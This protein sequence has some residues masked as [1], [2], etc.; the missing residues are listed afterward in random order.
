MRTLEFWVLGYGLH[1]LWQAPLILLAAWGM[2]RLARGAGVSIA[3]RIWVGALLLE[4]LL[5]ACPVGLGDLWRAARVWLGCGHGRRGGPGGG[6]SG[7]RAR[8]GGAAVATDGADGRCGGVY[9]EPAVR[10]GQVGLGIVADTCAAAEGE[11]GGFHRSG[12]AVA[13]LC[14]NAGR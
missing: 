4:A 8:G 3:H 11:A 1:A 10:R 5:P 7:R 12:G 14:G 13:A 2:T 9:G 6:W